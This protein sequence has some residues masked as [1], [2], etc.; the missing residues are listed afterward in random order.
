M[1]LQLKIIFYKKQ[2]ITCQK[3]F[4]KNNQYENNYFEWW[5]FTKILML[6][7][8]VKKL[9]GFASISIL[10]LIW[11]SSQKIRSKT[12]F[13][14]KN[15][16]KVPLEK[17]IYAYNIHLVKFGL[18]TITFLFSFPN[19]FICY[20]ISLFRHWNDCRRGIYS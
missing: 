10:K 6:T 11:H 4:Q 12:V 3:T 1:K 17:S 20:F 2:Q 14:P 18:Y 9:F 7:T 15:V 16:S 8:L 19:S 13:A 5:K